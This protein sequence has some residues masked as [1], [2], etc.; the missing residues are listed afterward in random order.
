MLATNLVRGA[1]IPHQRAEQ[2]FTGQDA[3]YPSGPENSRILC[4]YIGGPDAKHVWIPATANHYLEE[5]PETVFL[6]IWVDSLCSYAN[7]T[8]SGIA[9]VAAAK[10]WGFAPNLPGNERRWIVVDAE[11]NENYTYYYQCAVAIWSAG[12]RMLAYRSL[13]TQ[14]PISDDLLWCADWTNVEPQSIPWAGQ[15][16][17]ATTV[18]DYSVFTQDVL[19]GCGTGPRPLTV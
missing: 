17:M 5:N 7:G 1:H 10:K 19:S 15:Q 16:Y 14:G 8:E 11:T 4:V 9:A 18:W 13:Y 12:Y 3:A 6:P 2:L